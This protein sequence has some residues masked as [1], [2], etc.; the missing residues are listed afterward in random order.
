MINKNKILNSYVYI[1]FGPY[2]KSFTM[3]LYDLYYMVSEK[4][5][6]T[7]EVLRCVEFINTL[8]DNIISI[9]A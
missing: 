9:K 8:I 2:L 7:E 5:I 4:E 1:H 6:N 3:K